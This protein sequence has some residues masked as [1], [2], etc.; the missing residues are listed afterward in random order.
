LTR[1]YASKSKI[2]YWVIVSIPLVY[3]ASLYFIVY[4]EHLDLLGQLGVEYDPIYGYV[5]NLFLNTVRT[6][7]GIMFGIGFFVH[8]QLKNSLNLR[9]LS[10]LPKAKLNVQIH[11]QNELDIGR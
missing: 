9:N 5:Y 4:L 1:Y 3:F 11:V 7:G 2:K 6:G 8:A 10:I